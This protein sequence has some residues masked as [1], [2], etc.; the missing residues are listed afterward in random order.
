VQ[1]KIY[2]CIRIEAEKIHN[3]IIS[4]VPVLGTGKQNTI[5]HSSPDCGQK[6]TELIFAFYLCVQEIKNE[7]LEP[8]QRNAKNKTI[9]DTNNS[10]KIKNKSN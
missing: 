6:L 1:K 2:R 5:N 9:T 8:V 10:G 4:E 7:L 3:M